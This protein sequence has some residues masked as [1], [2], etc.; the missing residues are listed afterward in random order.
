MKESAKLSIFRRADIIIIAAVAVLAALSFFLSLK[1]TNTP[2]YASVKINGEQSGE[3]YLDKTGE[4]EIQGKNGIT[5]VLVVEKDGVSV[6]NA[7]CPDKLCEKTGK[8]TA[9]GQSIICLPGNISVS[10]ESSADDADAVVG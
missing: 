1:N 7:D 4:Y 3:Y 6:K 5:L 9:V 2:L 10:L 8:I